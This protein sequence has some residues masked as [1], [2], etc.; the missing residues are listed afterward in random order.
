MALDGVLMFPISGWEIERAF[1]HFSV[2]VVDAEG[3]PVA[4]MLELPAGFS[5]AI[6]RP[7]A[8]WVAGARHTVTS[9]LD[10]AAMVEEIYGVDS[11]GCNPIERVQEIVVDAGLLPP[12]ATP[13]YRVEATH[14]VFARRDLASLVCC[15][16]AFPLLDPVQGDC[17]EPDV[18]KIYTGTCASLRGTGWLLVRYE[19]DDAALQPTVASNFATRLINTK[20]NYGSTHVSPLT[21]SKVL[22]EPACLRFEILDLAHGERF[23]EERC[24]GEDLV[25]QLGELELDPSAELAAACAG[26]PY[27]CEVKYDAWDETRCRP[28]PE[29]QAVDDGC[30]CRTRVGPGLFA[31]LAVLFAVGRRRRCAT[32][33]SLAAKQL[34]A[35]A[36]LLGG[37]TPPNDRS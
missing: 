9:S 30:G 4:G 17:S 27:V 5:V 15:D 35:R 18:L 16:E 14:M 12:M 11:S 20:I 37:V 23:V 25:D 22:D 34:F 28:W 7:T 19:V 31:L 26:E 29:P 1:T 21:V 36:H 32:D 13:P 33:G 24:H 10:V 2:A 3:M 8:P 6:W